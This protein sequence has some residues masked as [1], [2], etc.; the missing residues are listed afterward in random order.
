MVEVQL[1]DRAGQ[2]RFEIRDNGVGFDPATETAGNGLKNM[3]ARAARMR[4]T[5]E[6][7]SGPGD[8]TTLVLAIPRPQRWRKA[9]RQPG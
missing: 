5:I 4:G 1:E 9:D 8:G 6:I 3:R 7:R 2:W